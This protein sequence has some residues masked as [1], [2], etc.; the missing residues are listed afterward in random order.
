VR[1]LRREMSNELVL[2]NHKLTLDK[3]N[4][5]EKVANLGAENDKYKAKVEEM[6]YERWDL[7]VKSAVAEKKATMF[8]TELSGLRSEL[9]SRDKEF[10]D[11]EIASAREGAQMEADRSREKKRTRRRHEAHSKLCKVGIHKLGSALVRI[12]ADESQKRKALINALADYGTDMDDGE[13]NSL[14]SEAQ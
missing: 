7:K 12:T 13:W 9:A 2:A 11:K 14:L 6:M 10:R 4:L 5:A 8:E 1:F 3:Q